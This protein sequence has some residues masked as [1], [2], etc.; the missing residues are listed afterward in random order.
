MSCDIFLAMKELAEI[1]GST[2]Q[3]IGPALA[4]LGLWNI[5]GGP[6]DKASSEGYIQYRTYPLRP[7]IGDRSL[8]IWH[9]EKTL[10]AL[11]TIGIVPLPEFT[12][13]P[14]TATYRA[15]PSYMDKH[16]D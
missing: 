15:R 9:K 3:R 12:A 4:R 13:P 14:A 10:A 7:D 11:K 5:N 16:G 2:Q 8:P 1:C 6:T